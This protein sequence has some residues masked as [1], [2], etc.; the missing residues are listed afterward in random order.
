MPKL[1]ILNIVRCALNLVRKLK[2]IILVPL[3]TRTGLA[4]EKAEVDEVRERHT[5]RPLDLSGI[6]CQT[7]SGC[8]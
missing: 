8:V 4:C 6:V 2:K 1:M 3:P 5:H 7:G